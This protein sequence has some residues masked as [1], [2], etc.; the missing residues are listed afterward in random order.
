MQ[1]AFT[2]DDL[3]L[4]PQSDPPHGFTAKG[5]VASIRRAL[6]DHGIDGVYAFSNSWPLARDPGLASILDDWVADGH[7]LANHTHGHIQLIDVSAEV[8]A[9]DIDAADKNLAPWIG[10]A[11]LRLFR[12]PLCHWGETDE[13]RRAINLH[14]SRAGLTPV[15]VTTWVY[16]WTWNRAWLAAREAGDRAA[17][18]F[19]FDSF[20]PFA[21]A[22]HRHDAAAAQA[23]FG[24]DTPGIAL[25]HNVAFFAE[26]ASD[27]FG[28]LI[29]AG[30]DFVPLERALTGAQQAAVG[31]VT[32]AEFLVLQQ[33]IAASAGRLLPKIAPDMVDVFAR[34][35]DMAAGR[36][37]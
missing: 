17:E 25:G 2:M 14:L 36:T 23:W 19:V 8:F 13:K 32:S 27:Y 28:G 5:I 35:A 30:V 12:H 26:I 20:V 15:D 7:H 6:A 1:L 3:P 10:A 18:R 34:A 21:I 11:P 31:S 22:Q 16:E 24:E 4:W 33:K 37:D 29:A 9:R